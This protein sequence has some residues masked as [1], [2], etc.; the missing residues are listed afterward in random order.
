[1]VTAVFCFGMVAVYWC[2]IMTE[3]TLIFMRLEGNPVTYTT[4]V[5]VL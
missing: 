1:M 5:V 2:Q 3:H 4:H